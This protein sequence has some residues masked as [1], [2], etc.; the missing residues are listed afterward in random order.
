VG[1]DL[2]HTDVWTDRRTD[3]TRLVVAFRNFANASK[4]CHI[5]VV[6]VEIILF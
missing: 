4:K 3:M 1:A 6:L 2:F 5:A